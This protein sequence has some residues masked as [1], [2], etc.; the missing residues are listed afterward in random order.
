MLLKKPILSTAHIQLTHIETAYCELAKIIKLY[1]DVYLPI[2]ERLHNEL[3][4]IESKN[5]IKQIALSLN[6]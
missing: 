5:A 4:I 6:K 1:G 2:F 3:K